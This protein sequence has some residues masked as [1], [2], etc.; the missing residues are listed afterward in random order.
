MKRISKE[1]IRFFVK[2]GFV[3]VSTIDKDGSIHTS[4][5]G[6]VGVEKDGG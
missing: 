4:A 6:I 5:K 3:I 1:I 2:Q